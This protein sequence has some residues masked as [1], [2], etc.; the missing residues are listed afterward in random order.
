MTASAVTPSQTIGPFFRVGM[1]GVEASSLVALD[2]TGAIAVTGRV[3]DGADNPVPDAVVEIW[4]AN[5][6]GCFPPETAAGWTGFGR[7]FTEDNGGF[8]F[9]TVKPG[10]VDEHQAPHI[11]ISVFARGLLQR[12]MTRMYFPDEA[13]ANATDPV[14]SSIEDPATRATLV[15]SGSPT[16][17]RFDIHLQGENETVFFVC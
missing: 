4:Q 16:G 5:A 2:M 15:A 12:V 10:C 17:L 3:L 13:A 8:Q 6:Q 11:D 1:A 7:C 9:V 14:L